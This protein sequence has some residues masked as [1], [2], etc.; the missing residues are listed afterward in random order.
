M[1]PIR[2]AVISTSRS[3]FG[4]LEPVVRRAMNDERF[5]AALLVCGHHLVAGTPLAEEVAGLPVE[6]IPA[7]EGTI[8]HIGQAALCEALERSRTEV[9]ILLGDRFELLS[10]AE[11]CTF[12]R[13]P[14]GHCSGGERTLG[15]FDDQIRDAVT[16]LA[17]L[18]FVS[19][20]PAAERLRSLGE[21]PWRISVTGD[22]GLDSLLAESRMTPRD[23]A[24]RVGIEP[25]RQDIVVALHP[26]TRSVEETTFF[27]DSLTAFCREFEGHSFLSSP[28]GDPGSEEIL[29]RWREL[30][31]A[32]ERCKVLP[33]LGARGFRGLVAACGALAG[34][35]SSGI[36][37][38][39]SLGTPSLDLG[40]RQL[41]RVRGE[42]VTTCAAGDAAGVG[43]AIRE[44]LSEAG[45]RRAR[46]A[47][48]PYGDGSA[49]PRI[50]NHVAEYARDRRLTVKA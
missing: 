43:Q 44:L 28:N 33:S 23:L 22:P 39:P 17:Q 29:E 38:A 47:P 15:A 41:G 13:V 45:Q 9:A 34:N 18:H 3:D 35:S 6:R 48:N 42:S 7:G 19:H 11:C 1:Q 24:G 12:A 36:W 10:V 46:I 26:V 32:N 25:T 30:A 16:R 37:E 49:A 21:E 31:A 2:L 50:L 27:L 5:N 20:E 40:T 4:L 8:D 14:I